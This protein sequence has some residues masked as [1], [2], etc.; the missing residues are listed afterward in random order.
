MIRVKAEDISKL[1][2]AT[3][4][5]K[6]MDLAEGDRVSAMARMIA[7]KKK[8]PKRRAGAG[9][10]QAMLDLDVPVEDADSIDVGG[11]EEFDESLL[12]E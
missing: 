7:R 1:G 12:D 4:G 11:E 10:A 8:A 6:I 9:E 3:Q 5:V 2:R